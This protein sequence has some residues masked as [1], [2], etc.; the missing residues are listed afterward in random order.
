MVAVAPLR[1]CPEWMARTSPQEAKRPRVF[2]GIRGFGTLIGVFGLFV[3]G[4]VVC[5]VG[6]WVFC[7]GLCVC[8]GVPVVVL[9]T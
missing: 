7:C 1:A 5:V 6:F 9:Y 3:V 4:W 2:N 8:V